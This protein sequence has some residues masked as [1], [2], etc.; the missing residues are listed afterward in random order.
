MGEVAVGIGFAV[1]NQPVESTRSS[2][3]SR[4]VSVGDS[5]A[6]M[7]TSSVELVYD[8]VQKCREAFRRCLGVCP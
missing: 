8:A 6:A 4:R 7:L 3:A 5:A 1:G 2:D